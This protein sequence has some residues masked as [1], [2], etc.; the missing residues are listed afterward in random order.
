MDRQFGIHM[1]QRGSELKEKSSVDEFTKM[2][3]DLNCLIKLK[4]V[5]QK[6]ETNPSK[7]Y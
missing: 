1:K 5:Q 7:H 4:L 2:A 6:I 3:L